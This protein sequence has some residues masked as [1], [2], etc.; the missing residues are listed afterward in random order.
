[1]EQRRSKLE[2][3][4]MLAREATMAG[5]GQEAEMERLMLQKLRAKS[6]C[7]TLVRLASSA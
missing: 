6:A 1:M 3:E 5:R 4:L 2:R 7:S